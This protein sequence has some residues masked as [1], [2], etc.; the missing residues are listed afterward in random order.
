MYVLARP[1]IGPIGSVP[2]GT[3]TANPGDDAI[4]LENGKKAGMDDTLLGRWV[5]VSGRLERE[6]SKNADN[7]RELDVESFQ[8]VKVVVPRAAAPPPRRPTPPR[9][10]QTPPPAPA[11]AP[12]PGPVTVA[13][14]PPSLPKT[15]SP[16]P[17]I[18]LVGLLSLA[19]GL[20]LRSFRSRE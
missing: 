14:E 7:L 13:P 2:E 11:P 1:R 4:E 6:T 16:V 19:A 18:G 12:V 15:A 5:E 10:V 8:L 3:C 20:L 17:A 9:A